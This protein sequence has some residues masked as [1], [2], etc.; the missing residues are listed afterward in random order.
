MKEVNYKC[1]RGMVEGVALQM[2]EEWYKGLPYGFERG[3]V[4]GVALQMRKGGMEVSQVYV[5]NPQPTSTVLSRRER[6]QNG[7]LYRQGRDG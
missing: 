1:E 3:M 7:Q 5:F 4:E 2:R 6:W